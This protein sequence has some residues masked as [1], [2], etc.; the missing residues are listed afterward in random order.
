MTQRTTSKEW[1]VS[2][3]YCGATQGK[4]CVGLKIIG[5]GM[6]KLIFPF[7]I[8]PESNLFSI[9]GDVEAGKPLL[10]RTKSNTSDP[11][12][13]GDSNEQDGH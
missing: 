12:K 6:G 2:S 5:E 13:C 4:F 7:L 1:K 8:A 9:V 3:F 11:D 10:E